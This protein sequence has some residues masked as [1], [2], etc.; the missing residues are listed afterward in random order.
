MR[1]GI[2]MDVEDINSTTTIGPSGLAKVAHPSLV[3]P[4]TFV[5][6]E[7]AAEII[8]LQSGASPK[9]LTSSPLLAARL[10]TS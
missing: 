4:R 2:W 5:V 7:D 6:L 3:R 9:E 8:P 10:I 1:L